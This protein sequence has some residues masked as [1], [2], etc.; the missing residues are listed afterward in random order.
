MFFW[1]LTLHLK[2]I[3]FNIASAFI[4]RGERI[5]NNTKCKACGKD[6]LSNA[7]MCSNCGLNLP[8]VENIEDDALKTI[9]VEKEEMQK[10]MDSIENNLAVKRNSN[11]SKRILFWA[12]GG[13]GVLVIVGGLFVI[14]LATGIYIYASSSDNTQAKNEDKK[15]EIY[16]LPNKKTEK[17][18]TPTE[19]AE[20]TNTDIGDYI[21]KYKARVGRYRLQKAVTPKNKFFI[22]AGAEQVAS[23]NFGRSKKDWVIVN[24][25][26]YKTIEE[27][28]RFAK[29]KIAKV[30]E[31]GGKVITHKDGKKGDS[32]IF[33]EKGKHGE[34]IDCSEGICI[35]ILASSPKHVSGFYD[36]FFKK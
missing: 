3:I 30:L 20:F 14:T 21:K 34:I 7:T 1:F 35:A 26:T 4:N 17:K 11:N 6:N 33:N 15:E 32:I 9:D 29:N 2:H 19:F 24:V 22:N 36:S 28:K 16:K 18:E 8:K 31:D 5:M 25:A 23:Y 10:T 27:S 12:L 13:L